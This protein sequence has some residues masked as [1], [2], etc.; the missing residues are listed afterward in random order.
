MFFAILHFK[1]KRKE[2]LKQGKMFFI[3]FKSLF[4]SGDV[5][6]FKILEF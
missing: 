3:P 4:R 1:F 2:P 6:N 5:S